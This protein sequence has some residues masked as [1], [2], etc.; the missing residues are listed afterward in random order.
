M[1]Q[2]P[3]ETELRRRQRRF[4]VPGALEVETCVVSGTAAPWSEYHEGF[5]LCRVLAGPEVAW[6]CGKA[7]HRRSIERAMVVGPGELHVDCAAQPAGASLQI[8]R[9]PAAIVEAAAN[10]REAETFALNDH[11][12]S[13]GALLEA[14]ASLH[15]SI[16]E[17]ADVAE[18][19]SRLGECLRYLVRMC[20]S[21]E[22]RRIES[23]EHVVLKRA[24]RFMQEHVGESTTLDDLAACARTGKYHLVKLFRRHLG[25]PPQA[26]LMHMRASRARTLL[27]RGSPCGVVAHECGFCD[28]SHLNRW[29]KRIYGVNPGLYLR[30]TCISG[31]A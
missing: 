29:F 16:E 10:V 26:Y 21:T 9:I 19:R 6:R 18:V 24:R 20:R 3:A 27:L 25:C 11:S 13:D 15:A 30:P 7:T 28:Q 17:R 8:L 22:T 31:A 23:E 1:V 4:V 2:Q 12:T 5:T 14:L